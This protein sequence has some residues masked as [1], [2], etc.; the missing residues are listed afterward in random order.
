MYHI[1]QKEYLLFVNGVKSLG[2][3]SEHFSY[4][5][6]LLVVDLLKLMRE[7]CITLKKFHEFKE[8]L[9]KNLWGFNSYDFEPN[10]DKNIHPLW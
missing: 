5:W 9:Q 6:I 10:I 1:N 2:S 3:F 4:D 7:Y 8:I